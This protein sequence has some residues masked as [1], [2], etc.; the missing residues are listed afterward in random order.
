MRTNGLLLL[1]GVPVRGFRQDLFAAL[2]A[3]TL[4]RRQE[5]PHGAG[6]SRGRRH[7]PAPNPCPKQRV[8]GSEESRPWQPLAR[9]QSGILGPPPFS[10]TPRRRATPAG[11]CSECSARPVVA[12]RLVRDDGPLAARSRHRRSC[13]DGK[14]RRHSSSMACAAICAG[15]SAAPTAA[16][17]RVRDSCA[18]VRTPNPAVPGGPPAVK[19]PETWAPARCRGAPFRCGTCSRPRRAA[20][21]RSHRRSSSPPALCARPPRHRRTHLGRRARVGRRAAR[22][23]PER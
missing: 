19:T 16:Q 9:R 13:P 3:A 7:T 20:R 21:A 17:S 1:G 4:R 18:T 23:S 22:R 2:S 12:R 15:V 10:R 14:W 6:D 11:G 8:Q 5:P